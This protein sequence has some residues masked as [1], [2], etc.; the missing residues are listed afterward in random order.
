MDQIKNFFLLNLNNYDN[1]NIDFPIGAFLIAI[2]LS[3]CVA[4]F[5]INDYK[6]KTAALI[7]QLS[8]HGAKS[9]ETAKTFSELRIK[10]TLTVRR[11]L[12]GSGQFKNIVK[13]VGEKKESYEEYIERTKSKN[14]NK[15]EEKIDFATAR[16]YIDPEFENRA[17]R[18]YESDNSGILR[19]ILISVMLVAIL[20][21]LVIFLPELLTMIN[22][23]AN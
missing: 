9:E 3:F 11:A 1:I 23:S 6:S 13:R 7:K 10:N 12:M 2:T 5:V 17:K 18:I 15:R 4:S 22:N 8:R 21:C 19:P 14:K 16:F 20:I